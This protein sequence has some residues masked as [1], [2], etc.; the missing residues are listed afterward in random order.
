MK[1]AIASGPGRSLLALARGNWDIVCQEH[2]PA[3]SALS[4]AATVVVQ[5]RSQTLGVGDRAVHGIADVDEERLVGLFLLV[6]ENP[7]VDRCRR[8]LTRGDEDRE[9]VGAVVAVGPG[10]RAVGD[11]VIHL[12]RLAARRGQRFFCLWPRRFD[13][14]SL[15]ARPKTPRIPTRA[16]L[17]ARSFSVTIQA[18]FARNSIAVTSKASCSRSASGRISW[19]SRAW[20]SAAMNCLIHSS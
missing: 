14:A 5:N 16:W 11:G 17:R 2:I 10:S 3:G 15:A 20:R 7:H 4:A 12:N 13:F 6:G 1:T 9:G 8:R 19:S 18:K